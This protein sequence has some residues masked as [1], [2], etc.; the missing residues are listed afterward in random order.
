MPMSYDSTADTLRH[1]GRVQELLAAFAVELVRRGEA[2]DAS[3]LGPAEKPARD[4]NP[5][6]FE[7]RFG[8][9]HLRSEEMKR[10]IA[11]HH[12]VNSHHPEFYGERG[13]AGMDLFDL[14]EMFCDWKAAGEPYRHD[15][16]ARSI[17]INSSR[18]RLDPQLQAILINTARRLGWMETSL[19]MSPHPE[20]PR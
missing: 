16:I 13:V 1:I 8:D 20:Q 2:H 12:A 3:K 11:S 9:P 19:P 17:E 10:A 18:H 6:D 5:P 15:T 14:V 7:H 4:A